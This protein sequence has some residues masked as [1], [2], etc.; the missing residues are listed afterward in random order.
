[1]SL[2]IPCRTT[3]SNKTYLAQ[4]A[5][6]WSAGDGRINGPEGALLVDDRPAYRIRA[7][8]NVV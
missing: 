7:R 8:V 5:T 3:Y 1:M 6:T 2:V 4:E